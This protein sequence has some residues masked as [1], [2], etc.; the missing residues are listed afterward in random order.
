MR[1]LSAVLNIVV[2]KGHLDIL[3]Y[4]VEERNLEIGRSTDESSQHRPPLLFR[5]LKHKRYDIIDY[6]VEKKK[7]NLTT[8]DFKGQNIL[9]IAA[10]D[11]DLN[12]I[13]YLRTR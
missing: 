11:C 4:F 7:A 5:S 3:K 8:L 2:Q 1:D 10:Q 12:F 13:Q 6:L 9:Y